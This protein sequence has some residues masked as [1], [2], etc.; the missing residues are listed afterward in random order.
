MERVRLVLTQYVRGSGNAAFGCQRRLWLPPSPSGGE[1]GC[2]LL[3][4]PLHPSLIPPPPSCLRFVGEELQGQQA[5][6]RQV[7]GA[8]VLQHAGV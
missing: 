8:A 1:G 5:D 4:P 6:A 3:A 2:Q 7:V